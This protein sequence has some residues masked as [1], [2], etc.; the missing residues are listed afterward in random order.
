LAA[1]MASWFT[2]PVGAVAGE[3]ST[4]EPPEP[5]SDLAAPAGWMAE[6]RLVAMTSSH[7]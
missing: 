1:A 7:S 4:T 6:P 3:I 5:R 2:T